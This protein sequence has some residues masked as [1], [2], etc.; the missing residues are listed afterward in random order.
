MHGEHPLSEL[1]RAYLT[2][3]NCVLSVPETLFMASINGWS[4]R[5]VVAHLIGWNGQMIAASQEILRGE[6][7]QYYADAPN[8]YQNINTSFVARFASQ[9]KAELISELKASLHERAP[10]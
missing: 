7:P 5:D 6:T 9:S 2:F 1:K 10:A 4:P 3:C 8:D